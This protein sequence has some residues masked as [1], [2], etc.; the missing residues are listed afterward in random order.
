MAAAGVYSALRLPI[1][2][3]PDMTN[4][5]VTVITEAGSLSPVEVE[6]Y[7]TYPVESVM[8]GLPKLQELRSISRFGISVVTIVF[9]EDTDLY[10]ARQLVGER[11]GQ[12]AD[13]IPMN[14][15]TP[16]IGSLATALGEI[17]QFEVR[18]ANYTATELRTILE[19]EIVPK[20]RA[21]HGVTEV[22]THG[23]F[24]K[25]YEI[26]PSPERMAST[27]VTLE[28]LFQAL[29]TN[30][31]TA[32]GGYVVHHNE[33]QFIRGQPS[34]VVWMTCDASWYVGTTRAPLYWSRMWRK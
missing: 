31:R 20:L 27:G 30:N 17:L 23:G 13:L 29:E 10:W 5:Q 28:D 7:I 21:V 11:I 6:R 3:V 34:S 22:N 26:Q 19:W 32:G 1:D 15:G 2:A 9:E 33:Q 16:K 14:Y 25:T 18:G 12:A 8:G 24:Y 4:T